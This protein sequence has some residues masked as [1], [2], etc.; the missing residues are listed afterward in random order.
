MQY[1][2]DEDLMT[3]IAVIGRRLGLD[4]TSVQELGRKG[5]TDRALLAQAGLEQRCIVTANRNDFRRFTNAFAAEGRPHA[6]VLIVPYTLRSRGAV[7]VARALVAF[8]QSRGE[9][10]SAYLCDFLRPA[11]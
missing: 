6:G 3:D 11:E 9:F 10:P 7:A 4:V 1:L 5:W 8:E 2:I